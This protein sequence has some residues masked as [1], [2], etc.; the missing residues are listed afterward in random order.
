MHTRE[1]PR[2]LLADDRGA[3]MVMGIFMCSCLVGAL[4]YLAGIGDAILYRERLQEAAD[5]MAFSDAALHARGMNLLVLINLIMSLILGIRV[6]IR[7][8]KIV[9]LIATAVFAGLG[10]VNP[11]L[12]GATAP[13]SSAAV[14]LENVGNAIDP[15][16]D[17]ALQALN[18]VQDFIAK[19][20]PLL[21]RAG[22]T[23]SV[24]PQYHPV[25]D[26]YATS[27]LAGFANPLPVEHID[28]KVLC[29]NASVA[30]SK[31]TVWLLSQMPVPLPTIA[32]SWLDPIM[33]AI[34]SASPDYFCGL[35]SGGGGDGGG[36]GNG[37]DG[38]GGG[39]GNGGNGNGGGGGGG[40]GKNPALD[41]AIDKP[42]QDSA[43][44]RCKDLKNGDNDRQSFEK[45]EKEWLSHCAFAG[46]TC[47]SRDASGRPLEA[48]K[49]S[50][51]PVGSARDS[52][53]AAFELERLRHERD[54][55]LRS[56]TSL[57][58][59]LGE[60]QLDKAKCVEWAKADE[61]TRHADQ[62]Q[63]Q[64]QQRQESGQQQPNQQRQN[65]SS[66]Q[67][68]SS[69]TTASMKVVDAWHNGAK[70]GQ[71]IGGVRGNHA[72]LRPSAQLV[73]IA[74]MP[75]RTPQVGDTEGAKVPAIA[76]AEFFYDCADKWDSESCNKDEEAMWHFKW[77][78]RLRRF[79][80][81][82]DSTQRDLAPFL[83]APPPRTNPEAFAD[84]LAQ[85]ALGHDTFKSNAALRHQLSDALHDRTTRSQGIH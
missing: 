42:F 84:K 16:I 23:V 34:A 28:P 73:R 44:E 35:Q 61:K 69:S 54:Q 11:P 72:L 18:K 29:G 77:R 70:E 37:G 53:K 50:G 36:G 31:I 2:D 48:G 20:T 27:E 7:T 57:L 25:T 38:N 12:F 14:A 63:L 62:E 76:Q 78:A 51:R 66:S 40:P 75:K 39:G 46:V 65:E 4:W 24:G 79:N 45:K 71:I 22:A 58:P 85:D 59:K 13:T 17:E 55:A 83:L 10:I 9:T 15:A 19:G 81:P 43:V 6:A 56:L 74:T 64:K 30:F 33:S 52:Q 1:D 68:S 26:G 41:A 8:A 47:E 3:V 67:S 80:Q 82:F 21:A 60:F 32:V 5:A 49:Q